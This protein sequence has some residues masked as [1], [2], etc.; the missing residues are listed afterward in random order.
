MA[1]FRQPKLKRSGNSFSFRCSSSSNKTLSRA[2]LLLLPYPRIPWFHPQSQTQP[3][4]ELLTPDLIVS[5]L[6]PHPPSESK[7]V[8]FRDLDGDP[9]LQLSNRR[10]STDE[11]TSNL[12]VLL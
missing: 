11:M 4:Q 1:L 2:K 6:L 10:D 5:N 8:S 9:S 12:W 7:V 3:L